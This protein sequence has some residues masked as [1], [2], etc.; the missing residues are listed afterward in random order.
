VYANHTKQNGLFTILNSATSDAWRSG[1]TWT[2]S[3]ICIRFVLY[4]ICSN[5]WQKYRPA[6]LPPIL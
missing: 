6:D 5:E 4:Y 1:S 3:Y 2:F